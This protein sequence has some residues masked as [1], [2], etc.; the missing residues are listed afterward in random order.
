MLGKAVAN[1]NSEIAKVLFDASNGEDV[2]LFAGDTE[3]AST[4]KDNSGTIV[5]G[6]VATT[7]VTENVIKKGEIYSVVSSMPNGKKYTGTYMPILDKAGAPTW[8]VLHG[9]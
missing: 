2:V 6:F 9:S 1:G 4:L 5:N 8:Y 7:E 3:I